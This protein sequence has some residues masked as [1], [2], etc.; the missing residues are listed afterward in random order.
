MYAGKPDNWRELE[1][2]G[3]VE[4]VS[5]LSFFTKMLDFIPVDFLTFA[6]QM[7]NVALCVIYANR[8]HYAIG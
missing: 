3:P 5:F 2:A 7:R 6:I 1:R 8:E 4:K